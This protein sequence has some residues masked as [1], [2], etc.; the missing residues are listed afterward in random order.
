MCLSIKNRAFY[1]ALGLK[2]VYFPTT[3][4][5]VDANVADYSRFEWARTLNGTGRGSLIW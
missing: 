1:G 4:E 2:R 3:L 5:D